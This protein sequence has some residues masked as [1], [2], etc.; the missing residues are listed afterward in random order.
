MFYSEPLLSRTGPLARVWLAS[1]LERNLTKPQVLQ[2]DIQSSV[3]VIVDQGHAPLALRLSSHLMLGVVRIY[4]RKARYL[5]D[6]CNQA[7]IKIRMT[8]KST[9]NHD[10]PV[11]ATTA[12]DL[13]LPEMLT[14]EDLF[15]SMNFTHPMSQLPAAISDPS[16]NEED[17]TSSLN[18]QQSGTQSMLT[19]N[20][21][22]LYHTDDLN[23][24]FGDGDDV[25]INDTTISMNVGRNAPTPQP[26]G[27]AERLLYDDEDGLNLDFG[28]DTPMPDQPHSP[29]ADDIVPPVGEDEPL[30]FGDDE[31]LQLQQMAEGAH[32]VRATETPLSD[33]NSNVLRDLD[34]T[35]QNQQ[36]EEIEEVV[37][38]QRQRS[39][40]QK[41]IAPDV[42]TVLHKGQMKAQAEDRSKILRAPSL[43]PRDPLLLTLMNMQK[44]GDFVL[45][46]MND[47]RS[48]DW[49]PELQG[50]LSFETV[51]RSGQL[52]RKRDSGIAGLSEDE[53]SEK[54]PRLEGPGDAMEDEGVHLDDAQR[55]I[56]LDDTLP[57]PMSE[58]IPGLDDVVGDED[59][60]G[61]FGGDDTFDDTTVPLVHPAD[62]GPISLGTQHAVHLLRDRLGD[63]EGA[64]PASPAKKSVLL[65]D[66]VPEGR[67]SKEEA[68]KMF[69]E[70]L[71]L[72][73]KDAIK[74]DQPSKAIGLPLRIRAKRGL[75]GSWAETSPGEDPAAPT[76]SQQVAASA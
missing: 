76:A 57:R 3:A 1:N 74:V 29:M 62:S 47:G 13:N 75:W 34:R 55:D 24:D 43:L 6:D 11:H 40:K 64:H 59:D 37:V 49:A 44:N 63:A 19:P 14:V 20:E 51:T 41:P 45:N 8:F 60:G 30:E 67:T 35:F 10:L 7:L 27:D 36:E 23:L 4:G 50:L 33:A 66:L 22:T 25:D 39:K 26:A 15:S 9:N 61:I 73:T 46:A 52:K 18:P 58:G 48:R 65:Q 31:T 56:T 12:A 21:E 17:W 68:T 72:A 28:D 38:Q 5:L 2:S 69:F 70:V 71:V 32:G 54:S 16:Q 53:H 42:E